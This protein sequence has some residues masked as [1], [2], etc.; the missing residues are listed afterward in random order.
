[1]AGADQ[2]SFLVHGSVGTQQQGK[3]KPARPADFNKS[4]QQFWGCG[5]SAWESR[6]CGVFPYFGRLK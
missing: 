1:M 5:R 2:L 6:W 4:R 3:I